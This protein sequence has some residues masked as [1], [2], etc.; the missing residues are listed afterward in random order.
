M[1]NHRASK[2][3]TRFGK[4]NWSNYCIGIAALIT[5]LYLFLF[6]APR[7]SSGAL[8]YWLQTNSNPVQLTDRV[9]DFIPVVGVILLTIWFVF[10]KWE[11]KFSIRSHNILI[12]LMIIAFCVLAL[13]S[14][15]IWGGVSTSHLS[16]LQS[17][18][19]IYRTAFNGSSDTPY[20]I[21]FQCDSFGILCRES[22]RVKS[23][24]FPQSL[25]I[26]IDELSQIVAIMD[27]NKELCHSGNNS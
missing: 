11:Q 5:L 6:V 18:D 16:E 3:F 1:M 9:V 23:D 20:L 19:H 22:C 13:M 27:G 21:L 17:G 15:Y 10:G 8:V 7:W 2:T 25:S 26:G 12:P 24:N 4:E 14:I